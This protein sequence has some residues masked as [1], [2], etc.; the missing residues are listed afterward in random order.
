MRILCQLFF[1]DK[2]T[3]FLEGMKKGYVEVIGVY[4]SLDDS[5]GL[6]HRCAMHTAN[7]DRHMGRWIP[8]ADLLLASNWSP[9]VVQLLAQP[10][11]FCCCRPSY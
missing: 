9:L 5:V 2:S 4:S 7:I 3:K 10:C 11:T 8:L 6:T 1:Q